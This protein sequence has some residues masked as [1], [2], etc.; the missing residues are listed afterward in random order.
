MRDETAT[1]VMD[2]GPCLA[3]L[4]RD[5]GRQVAKAVIAA[6]FH[7]TLIEMAVTAAARCGCRRV[8]LAGGCFQNALLLEGLVLRLREAGHE[9]Y[10]PCSVPANDGGLAAGQC[11]AAMLGVDKE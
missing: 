5:L 7:R 4:L 9:P 10:W 11:Y 3:A 1:V 8:V 2:W 6:R